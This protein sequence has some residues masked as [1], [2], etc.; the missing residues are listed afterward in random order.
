M[1][2]DDPL[3]AQ[4]ADGDPAR[5]MPSSGPESELADRVRQRVLRAGATGGDIAPHHGGSSDGS[6]QRHRR[7]LRPFGTIAVFVVS[8]SVVVVVIGVFALLGHSA[9]TSRRAPASLGVSQ[10][11]RH[12]PDSA[13]ARQL[14]APVGLFLR[15]TTPAERAESNA[16]VKAD[17]HRVNA[18]QAPYFKS[19]F[20]GLRGGSRYKLYRL[21]E[22]YALIESYQSRI[23]PVTAPLTV[24]AQSLARLRLSNPIM[25]SFA[26]AL[27]AEFHATLDAP[28]FDSCAFLRG[29]AAHHFSLAW[30]QRSSYGKTATRVWAQ[31]SAAGNRAG[32]FWAWVNV[33]GQP[34]PGAQLFT[35]AQLQHLANLP[36]EVG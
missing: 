30:A 22:N 20:Q 12:Q 11:H 29:L 24:L 17:S 6:R 36:G 9:P 32:R 5:R 35:H 1:N 19:L 26:Q 3:I 14:Y 10:S 2:A 31:L 8:I 27:A 4:I 7:A 16:S 23:T 15:S 21:Y 25:Q 33:E 34:G 28:R 13:Q 18:C